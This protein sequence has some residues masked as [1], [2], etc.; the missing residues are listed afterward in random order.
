MIK[1]PDEGQASVDYG[2][3]APLSPA[4]NMELLE[5]SCVRLPNLLKVGAPSCMLLNEIGILHGRAITAI[6]DAMDAEHKRDRARKNKDAPARDGPG[7]G[8]AT[9]PHE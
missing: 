6:S 8:A 9:T 5:N 7:D 4:R 1:T 3:F 2:P